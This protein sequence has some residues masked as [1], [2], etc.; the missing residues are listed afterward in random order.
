MEIIDNL[1]D[2]ILKGDCVL[3]AGAGITQNSGGL[4]WNDLIDFLIDHF[5]YSSLLLDHRLESDYKIQIMDDLFQKNNPQLI[6]ETVSAR[7]ENVVIPNELSNLMKLPWF[8]V[9]T[10]NYDSAIEDSLSTHQ[11]P[12]RE[13]KRIFKG[14]EY[15]LPGKHGELLCVKLMGS[16]D[17]PFG[18]PG[19]MI[20]TS[21]QILKA[22]R[23]RSQ[24]FDILCSHAANLS[25][26]FIG[27]SFDDNVF[28][29]TIRRLQAELGQS[30]QK[31]YAIFKNEPKPEKRYLLESY[32]I[33][34][35]IKD[36]TDV[37]AELYEKYTLLDP[38]NYSKIKLQIGNKIIPLEKKVI[39]NFLDNYSIVDFYDISTRVSALSFFKGDTKGFYPFKENWHYPRQETEKLIEAII[40][41]NENKKSN[42]FCVSGNLGTG[43]TF[44]I[45]AAI[46]EL[47][48]QH[49][50]VVVRLQKNAINS[51]PKIEEIIKF[52]NE[53]LTAA[54]SYGLFNGLRLIFWAEFTPDP[55][56]IVR[57]RSIS[58]LVDFPIIL[59]FEEVAN[60]KYIEDLA[61]TIN[62]FRIDICDN[63]AEDQ[64]EDLIQFLLQTSKNHQFQEL[65]R[66]EVLRIVNEEKQF[67][68]I[69]YRSLDPSK[70]SVDQIVE[71]E[72]QKIYSDN[73]LR[74]LAIYSCIASCV[75][76]EIPISILLKLFRLK[77]N[78][79]QLSYDS[80]IDYGNQAYHFINIYPDR[81]FGYLFSIYHPIIA[82]KLVRLVTREKVDE[83]LLHIAQS[84]DIQLPID[85]KF[86]GQL[87]ITKGVNNIRRDVT[88]KIASTEK[89]LL[90]AFNEL[91]TH[92]PARP[93]I[94]HYAR[95]L[96][97]LEP[98]NK[99]AISILEE[100]L[101]EPRIKY[102]NFHER[103][104]NIQT[105]LAKFKWDF[106]KSS[107]LSK[108]KT[109][110]EL[111]EIFNLLETA[112]KADEPNIHAYYIHSLI[113]MD[114]F[115]AKNDPIEKIELL[116]EAVD[117]I[118]DGQSLLSEGDIFAKH[119]LDLLDERIFYSLMEINFDR[120]LELAEQMAVTNNGKGFYLLAKREFLRGNFDDAYTFI[121][122][123]LECGNYPHAILLK[124][125]LLF[126]EDNPPYKDLLPLADKGIPSEKET[127]ELAYYK[128]VIY[129]INGYF[130]AANRYFSLSRK[131]AP[132]ERKTKIYLVWIENVVPKKFT[133]KIL[134]D[135]T[136]SEGRIYD[137]KLPGLGDTIFFDPRSKKNYQDLSAGI[138]VTFELGFSPMG[139]VALGVTPK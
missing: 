6:Y 51:L 60:E 27:Y 135:F 37:S 5:N 73:K 7:L 86:I 52:K 55:E 110:S 101:P 8:S 26:L 92:Q 56:I 47:I 127:W 19:S 88:Y 39:F 123:S 91:Y 68:P 125:K 120:A 58:E 21:G 74:D 121:N 12:S 23:D 2:N 119:R 57:F 108:K 33:N 94:H 96:K 10:T 45:K 49:N 126:N 63:I 128:G 107:L 75:N 106:N 112:Q 95:L 89:G 99:I 35:L 43:R 44:T 9:F 29:D 76:L 61:Q 116:T 122:R 137:H 53:V 36:L 50:S 129:S 78:E 38:S 98:D 24:I 71:S 130:E 138:T 65:N 102:L 30:S 13:I 42:I 131:L 113:L 1:V 72:F 82:Q 84:V 14:N 48:T 103:K 105:T 90:H 80:I 70:A 93:I 132:K 114:L 67:L 100:A 31:Y 11:S 117:K 66:N 32:G 34:I 136:F 87:F 115:D 28:F 20:L 40:Q 59:I 16:S 69:M 54:E 109:D 139:P 118:N 25:F 85:A 124:M 134:S 104:A 77:Y 46:Y 4:S 111:S 41:P 64:R 81:Y 17:I 18:L 79:T 15:A 22:E 97:K 3:F 62:L 83:Y 133:G